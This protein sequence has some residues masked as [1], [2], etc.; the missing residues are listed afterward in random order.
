MPRAVIRLGGF[1]DL[2]EDSCSQG[3]LVL[4]EE[5]TVTRDP[6]G[7]REEVSSYKISEMIEILW[8][9][10]GD[11]DFRPRKAVSGITTAEHVATI[12]D[13]AA[14]WAQALR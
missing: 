8:L 7:S 9:E 6:F 1:P 12:A 11:H 13:H 14:R 10:D 4:R 2:I 3:S 5:A